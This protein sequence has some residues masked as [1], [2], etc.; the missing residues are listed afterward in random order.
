MND[1]S[2]TAGVI[3]ASDRHSRG[4]RWPDFP[5]RAL[6]RLVVSAV[7]VRAW[8]VVDILLLIFT[9]MWV[10]IL[11]VALAS[12]LTVSLLIPVRVLYVED[13]SGDHG[14]VARRAIGLM[15]AAC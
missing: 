11:G 15:A 2:G 3:R 6:A 14:P 4:G 8:F 12:P 9:G 10:G 7:L 1:P 13:I 5:R